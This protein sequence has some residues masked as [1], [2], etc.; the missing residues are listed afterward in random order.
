MS[1]DKIEQ[2][3]STA[4][5]PEQAPEPARAE[6]KPTEQKRAFVSAGEKIHKWGTYLSVDWILNAAAGVSFA[7]WGKV[8][9]TG[10]RRWSG[11]I[12][13]F[14][15]KLLGKII[16]KPELVEKAAAKGNMF[17]SII[18]GGMFT[19]P[20]LMML[21]SKKVKKSIVKF[22]DEKV[23]GKEQVENDPKFATA[24]DEIEHAPKKD[25]WTGMTSRFTALA[26]LLAIVLIPKTSEI[27]DKVYFNHLSGASEKVAK[28]LGFSG[29]K[30][31]QIVA[32][33][34]KQGNVTTGWKF[35]HDNVAMDAGLGLPYAGLH[36][37][38]Y[39][40]FAASKEKGKQKAEAAAAENAAAPPQT[41]LPAELPVAEPVAAEPKKFAEKENIVAS[42]SHAEREL[43]RQ[44]EDKAPA[45]SA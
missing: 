3:Q 19:I 24:Y 7:Y 17:V 14:F 10:K 33:V 30:T 34:D 8:T 5:A 20:P 15:S 40:M 45:L 21:E 38:F 44:S 43:A 22:F 16:D 6:T 18:A 28:K 27:A 26:P 41:A 23:Y 39:N 29:K 31:K 11:P 2:I 32:S 25:F 37:L 13:N 36:S 9:D 35:I 12:T 42:A 4:P 1:D